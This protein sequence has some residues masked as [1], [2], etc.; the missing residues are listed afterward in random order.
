MPRHLRPWQRL[1]RY[2]CFT[3]R[4][5]SNMTGQKSDEI[6][7]QTGENFNPEQP[8][9]SHTTNY[10]S[11]VTGSNPPGETLLRTNPLPTIPRS[12]L[13]VTNPSNLPSVPE[14]HQ[15]RNVS[16]KPPAGVLPRHS[17]QGVTT[18]SAPPSS[19]YTNAVANRVEAEIPDEPVEAGV[20]SR[21]ASTRT[22][23]PPY[24]P[25]GFQHDEDAPSLPE[26][27]YPTS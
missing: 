8:A 15:L 20:M 13:V 21:Q 27:T 25:G 19:F 3:F 22:V 24:S 12:S 26:Q 18:S 10:I 16:E 6:S 5:P 11:S 17:G 9:S 14:A 23:P 7:P 1:R 4:Y 2:F